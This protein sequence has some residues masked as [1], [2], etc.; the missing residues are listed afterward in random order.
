MKRKIV[1]IDEEKCNGCGQCID[2][3][4]EGALELVDGKARLVS[5]VYCDGLGACLGECPQGAITVEEREAESFDEA[6]VAAR[7]SE[8]AAACR[9]PGAAVQT[10]GDE[11]AAPTCPGQEAACPAEERVGC[12]IC[13]G[14]G[15]Q[16]P[17]SRLGHWPVQLRLVPPEA[18]F[19]RGADLVVLADCAAVAVPDFHDRYVA[20]R[21]V[22]VG[23]PKFDDLAFYR[24]K[25]ERIFG[26]AKPAGIT[27]LRMEVP[28][29]AGIADAAV[30]AWEAAGL[31]VPIEVHTIGIRGD[32][33]IQVLAEPAPS[34][35]EEGATQS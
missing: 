26:E 13:C 19:L 34:G 32:I 29:C 1:R 23:C 12:G 33:T 8:K 2:A 11:A 3:C 25:L 4:V 5:D 7:A 30:E 10:F 28:C 14:A 17:P 20:G 24:K 18:P 31:D 16:P 27:V 15:D 22:L 21:A 6:A 35:T 9:C